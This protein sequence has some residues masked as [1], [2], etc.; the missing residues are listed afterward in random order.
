MMSLALELGSDAVLV[1][2]SGSSTLECWWPPHLHGAE[3]G[4]GA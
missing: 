3:P 2:R 1:P 4:A